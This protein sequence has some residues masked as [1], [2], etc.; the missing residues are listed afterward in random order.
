MIAIAIDLFLGTIMIK[1]STHNRRTGDEQQQ[2]GTHRSPVPKRRRRRGDAESDY[3]E[4]ED[5]DER[6]GTSA[7]TLRRRALQDLQ[8]L[9]NNLQG[10]LNFV[11]PGKSRV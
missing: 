3:D 7:Q 2:S 1:V 11:I 9:S 4:D 5:D 8:G 6:P 10:N